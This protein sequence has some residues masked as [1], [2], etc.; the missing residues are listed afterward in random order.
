MGELKDKAD[1]LLVKF[2]EVVKSLNDQK[3][4]LVSVAGDLKSVADYA[5]KV[6]EDNKRLVEENKKL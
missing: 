6:D 2:N 3:D 5:E 4:K 1:N